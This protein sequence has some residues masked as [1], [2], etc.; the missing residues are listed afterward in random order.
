[1]KDHN[2]ALQAQE[3]VAD[4]T[5]RLIEQLVTTGAPADRLLDI[6][7]RIDAISDELSAFQQQ[8]RP[9]RHFN[10][11]LAATDTPYTLPYSPV[12]GPCNPIAPP[13]LPR[14]NSD[15]KTLDATV[16]CSRTFEGPKGLVHGAVIAAIYDQLLALLTTCSGKPSFTAWLNIQY[17]KPNPLHQ[18]LHFH[19]WIASQE[20]RK[21]VIKGHCKLGDDILSE[22]EG[23]FIT[24]A[25]LDTETL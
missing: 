6:R 24:P 4:S 16:N 20:G 1:M 21:T 8:P 23:L 3:A 18:P 10:F 11:D 25:D 7:R 19:A 13:L 5:R 17:K 9:I 12:S 2:T 22:A 15:N 14:Y